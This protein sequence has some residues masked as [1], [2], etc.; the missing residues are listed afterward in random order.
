MTKRT[1]AKIG[2]FGSGRRPGG[3]GDARRG[4]RRRLV[5]SAAKRGVST[6]GAARRGFPSTIGAPWCALVEDA[7]SV[8]ALAKALG[9]SRN[10]LHCWFNG[11]RPNKLSRGSVDRYAAEQKLP[12]PF[13]G[14]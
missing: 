4:G 11:R 6:D 2:I 8:T 1:W 3:G 7:G 10:T 14:K 12:R 9:V 5:M 13:G